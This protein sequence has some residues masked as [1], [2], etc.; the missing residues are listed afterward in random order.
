ML[1]ED[2][3]V[4]ERWVIDIDRDT[5]LT[6]PQPI[7]ADEARALHEENRGDG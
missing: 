4:L 3:E 7:C 5:R 1:R 2:S 6:A